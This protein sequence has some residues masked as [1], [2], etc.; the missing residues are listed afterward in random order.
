[1]DIAIN[2]SVDFNKMLNKKVILT[3]K[4][5]VKVEG[6]LLKVNIDEE[7]ARARRPDS[8]SIEQGIEKP[9]AVK[10][11]HRSIGGPLMATVYCRSVV[12][13]EML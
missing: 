13:V 5:G 7:E 4:S 6:V 11:V 3:L 12:K 9:M 1:M 8:L 2:R 10:K